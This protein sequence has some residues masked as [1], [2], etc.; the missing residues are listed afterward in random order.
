MN[1]PYQG[2]HKQCILPFCTANQE[3]VAVSTQS[4]KAGSLGYVRIIA[5][6]WRGRRLFFPEVSGLRPTGDRVRETLFNWLMP[7]LVGARCL[8]LFAG[9]GALGFEAASRGASAVIMIEQNHT[10]YQALLK[11]HTDLSASNTVDIIHQDALD[12]LAEN[13]A[14]GHV[15]DIV[16]LDPPFSSELLATAVKALKDGN[17]L[18]PNALIYCEWT[19][20][21][22][23]MPIQDGA[24][25]LY[26]QR[27]FGA[28]HTRL[29]R[30]Q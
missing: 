7:E 27:E 10:A 2:Y 12:W 16:F 20:D 24:W 17:W 8:D 4:K 13:N 22:S 11:H 3:P 28:V 1:C 19:V 29:Y 30:S 14:A 6:R 15:F 9:S 26:R 18:A 25:Q 23:L 21:Q 5:G